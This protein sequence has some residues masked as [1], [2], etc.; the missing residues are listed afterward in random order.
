MAKKKPATR[1]DKTPGAVRRTKAPRDVRRPEVPRAGSIAQAPGAAK[2]TRAASTVPEAIGAM[3]IERVPVAKINPAPY[4]PRKDLK[5]GDPEYKK[6]KQSIEE[7]GYVDPS[8]RPQSALVRTSRRW[9]GFNQRLARI[10]L[11][12]LEIEGARRYRSAGDFACRS[13]SRLL[14]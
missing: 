2:Q 14:R 6:L 9:V 11:E 7:F 10:A 3:V 12:A 1:R 4:N 8:S 13:R 5:P